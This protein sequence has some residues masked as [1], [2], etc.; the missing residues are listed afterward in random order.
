MDVIEKLLKKLCGRS[1][2]V[3]RFKIHKAAVN[4]EL[5]HSQSSR[6]LRAVKLC[7]TAGVSGGQRGQEGKKKT[8]ISFYVLVRTI[9]AAS[10][11]QLL[12]IE[13]WTEGLA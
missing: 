11:Y 3:S 7:K 5:S 2:W 10:V 13:G 12:L 6:G 4:S 1:Q 9:A 8:A